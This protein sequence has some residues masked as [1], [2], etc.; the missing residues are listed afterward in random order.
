MNGRLYDP[1]LQRFLSPDPYVISPTNAQDY[2]RYSYVLNNPLMYTDPSGYSRL[3]TQE[4]QEAARI[5]YQNWWNTWTNQLENPGGSGPTGNLTYNWNNGTYFIGNTPITHYQAMNLMSQ[6]TGGQIPY[7][8]FVGEYLP[9]GDFR[10]LHI[11]VSGYYEIDYNQNNATNQEISDPYLPTLN[12]TYSDM[13]G[14]L[15]ISIG[16]GIVGAAAAG[17]VPVIAAVAYTISAGINITLW[18]DATAIH[19]NNHN[20]SKTDWIRYG[21]NTVIT[22]SGLIPM[23]TIPS[24]IYSVL[25]E[26]GNLDQIWN[27]LNSK[28]F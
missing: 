12:L 8:W 19:I 5:A 13:E 17:E 3:S 22:F 26:S 16:I 4:E 7:G 2:N 10:I 21:V 18:Y 11:V 27:Y 24:A 6:L 25:D 9:N 28:K 1:Y 15:G 23:F 20:K 14:L